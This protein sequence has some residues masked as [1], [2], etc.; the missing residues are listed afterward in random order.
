MSGELDDHDLYEVLK[1]VHLIPGDQSAGEK[2][3][4]PFYNLESYVAIE[5]ANFSLGERQLLVLARALLKRSKIIVMDEATSNVDYETDAKITETLKTSFATGTTLIT[6]AHRL[7]TII[8]FDHVIV[9]DKGRIVEEG[10]P[11]ELIKSSSSAFHSLCSADGP[12]EY[13]HLLQIADAADRR[14]TRLPAS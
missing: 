13:E 12:V 2:A 11:L 10:S 3:K 6:I 9:L 5:G 4:N 7:R 14:I 8:D 1:R